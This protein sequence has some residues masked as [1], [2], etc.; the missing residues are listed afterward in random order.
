MVLIYVTN[1][2]PKA[3]NLPSLVSTLPCV[4]HIIMCCSL[5]VQAEIIKEV[6]DVLENETN[7][8]TFSCQA[9]GEPVPIINWYFN[10]VMMN[11]SD[12]NKYNMSSLMN[13]TTVTSSL[14]VMNTQSSDVG[15][16]TCSAKNIIGNNQSSGVL[17]VNG[18]YA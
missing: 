3:G 9:I 13:G 6:N 18:K 1:I 7:P 2:I 8:I 12:T 10:G 5:L 11:I 16:Y 14:T 4:Q 17:T 15:T